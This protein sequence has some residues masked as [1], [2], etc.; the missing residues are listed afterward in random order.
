[1]HQNLILQQ[2]IDNLEAAGATATALPLTS[3]PSDQ[4]SLPP[5]KESIDFVSPLA[6]P[7]ENS[8]GMTG[9]DYAFSIS[10]KPGTIR[11]VDQIGTYR[12]E[13]E[14]Y[15]AQHQLEQSGPHHFRH[16]AFS[17]TRYTGITRR[18]TAL[19][20]RCLPRTTSPIY[21]PRH[22]NKNWDAVTATHNR[23]ARSLP[24]MQLAECCHF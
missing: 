9:L 5:T 3:L 22:G 16:I 15:R 4:H 21:A 24:R 19:L 8:I 23:P 7:T 14:A 11:Y 2:M 17:V 12:S 18:S 13:T 1:M 10:A 20:L 6:K